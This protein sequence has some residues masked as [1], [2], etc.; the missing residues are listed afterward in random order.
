MSRQY[1]AKQAVLKAY[2]DDMQSGVD[3]FLEFLSVSE[4]D[5]RHEEGKSPA[6]YI[7]GPD[8]TS[9]ASA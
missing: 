5:F 3:L 7:Y 2:P 4:E 8:A 9:K 1:D 6:E